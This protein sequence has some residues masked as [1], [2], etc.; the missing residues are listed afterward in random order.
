MPNK[1][2]DLVKMRFPV[3][4]PCFIPRYNPK[5]TNFR[6][7]TGGFFIGETAQKNRTIDTDRL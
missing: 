2:Q 1:N 3:S 6:Q 4:F 7:E 5:R